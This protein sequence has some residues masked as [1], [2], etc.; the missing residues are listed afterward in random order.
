MGQISKTVPVVVCWAREMEL[1]QVGGLRTVQ[2]VSV[3]G[4]YLK[5]LPAKEIHYFVGC[6]QFQGKPDFVLVDLRAKIAAIFQMYRQMDGVIRGIL[7]CSHAMN[8]AQQ[9]HLSN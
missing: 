3:E 7:L 6:A 4:D 9:I 2:L 8:S 1:R 5:P